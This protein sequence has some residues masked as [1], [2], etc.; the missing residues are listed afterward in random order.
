MDQ[1]IS[2]IS[3]VTTKVAVD[4]NKG[5]KKVLR[6]FFPPSFQIVYS[7]LLITL[8]LFFPHLIM[9]IPGSFNK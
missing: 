7:G 9:K 1:Y 4:S 2:T 6:D 5:R 8:Y 3:K